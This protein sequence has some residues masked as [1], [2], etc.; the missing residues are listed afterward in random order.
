[1][2]AL[3]PS[4]ALNFMATG[5]AGVAVQGT[6]AWDLPVACVVSTGRRAEESAAAVSTST[7]TVSAQAGRGLGPRPG[8]TCATLWPL[9]ASSD[10]GKTRE[11]PTPR[12]WPPRPGPSL[13]SAPPSWPCPP[14]APP[15]SFTAPF[16]PVLVSRTPPRL[17]APRSAFCSPCLPPALSPAPRGPPS[18]PGSGSRV[19]RGHP[20][21]L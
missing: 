7:V 10:A 16:G 21:S 2:C 13:A 14:S 4:S 8:A 6:R 1:M 5:Q 15:Q 9:E 17:Q 12:P 3:P 18:S 11:A 20:P 19:P